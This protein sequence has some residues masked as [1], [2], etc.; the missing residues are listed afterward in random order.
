MSL[1]LKPNWWEKFFHCSRMKQLNRLSAA[2]PF[3][4][5]DRRILI[6]WVKCQWVQPEDETQL[7]L[8]PECCSFMLEGAT[9]VVHPLIRI[10]PDVSL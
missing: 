1:E 4:P 5:A 9:E 3:C 10:H 2:Q 8:N 7:I 6:G